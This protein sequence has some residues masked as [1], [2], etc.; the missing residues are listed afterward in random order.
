[1]ADV[2][3]TVATI[4]GVGQQGGVANVMFAKGMRSEVIPSGVASATGSIVAEKRNF[5]K[6][7][8]DTPVWVTAG[9]SPTAT[10][11]NG[12]YV[13]NG[14]PEYIALDEGDRIAVLDV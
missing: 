14:I 9:E 10:A 13:S 7:V 1:M 12:V 5:A 3:V 4:G 2:F 11:T 6:I 8:C